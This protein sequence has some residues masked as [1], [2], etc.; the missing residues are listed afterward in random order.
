MQDEY[1][2]KIFEWPSPLTTK[3]IN[4]FL[5]FIGYYRTFI[6]RFSKRTNEL[7]RMNLNQGNREEIHGIGE[8]CE[9]VY[10]RIP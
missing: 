10:L 4:S 5:G 9:E 7:N 6:P 3:E 2:R 1:V 8:I